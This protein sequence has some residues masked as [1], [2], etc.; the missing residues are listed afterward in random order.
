MSTQYTPS[1]ILTLGDLHSITYNAAGVFNFNFTALNLAHKE[2][3]TADRDMWTVEEF[4]DSEFYSLRVRPAFPED[5]DAK[6]VEINQFKELIAGYGCDIYSYEEIEAKSVMVHLR[7]VANALED[8]PAVWSIPC[9]EYVI[10]IWN[11]PSEE[12]VRTL[13][14]RKKHEANR[15]LATG[16]SLFTADTISAGRAYS[17][18]TR[19]LD[20]G[21]GRSF[22]IRIC[23]GMKEF[24]LT[25][26]EKEILYFDMNELYAEYEQVRVVA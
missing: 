6:Q 15:A 9:G 5:A 12:K 21:E 11:E 25:I 8:F 18:L 10:V 23:N 13:L 20:L 1:L 16:C 17:P 3:F 2:L 4:D 26:A 14:E 7:D 24:I 22:E 19:K